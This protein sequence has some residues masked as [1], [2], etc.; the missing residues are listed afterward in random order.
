MT[1]TGIHTHEADL[2]RNRNRDLTALGFIVI[3]GG[4]AV[5]CSHLTK[6]NQYVCDTSHE[7]WVEM[8]KN[9]TRGNRGELVAFAYHFNLK[10]D[11][12]HPE[13]KIASVLVDTTIGNENPYGDFIVRE[14]N[15]KF[16]ECAVIF[17]RGEKPNSAIRAFVDLHPS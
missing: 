8:R 10:A 15:G 9:P 5:S 1:R 2:G 6:T 17:Y 3:A 14:Q 4:I 13:F 12:T 7:G 16:T 11:P